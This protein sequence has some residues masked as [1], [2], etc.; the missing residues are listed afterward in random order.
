MRDRW[1]VRRLAARVPAALKVM[2]ARQMLESEQESL[3]I[4]E[5]ACPACEG[6]GWL[7]RRRLERCPICCG[8]R[9]VP[10]GLADW[11]RAQTAAN[12]EEHEGHEE[13]IEGSRDDTASIADGEER[14]AAVAEARVV[15]VAV[16]PS[17]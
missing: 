15:L 10:A 8:F 1:F 5:V 12:H 4:D 14:P 17:T 2:R 16:E 9:E 3:G 11:F 13:R 6:T 7:S